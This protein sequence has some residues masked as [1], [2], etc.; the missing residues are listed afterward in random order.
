MK[1]LVASAKKAGFSEAGACRM[2]GVSRGSFR[3][4]P[5]EKRAA[6]TRAAVVAVRRIYAKSKGRYGSPRVYIGLR[7]EGIKHSRK[8]VA[9]L[10]KQEGLVG[11]Q[12]RRFVPTTTDSNH[13]LA[14]APNTLNRQ[15]TVEAPNQV[16]V[17]DITYL[18]I[19]PWAYLATVID[20]YSRRVV[21]WALSTNMHASLATEALNMAFQAR[22]DAKGVLVHHDRGSQYASHAY[23]DCLAPQGANLSMSRKG[24]CWDNAVAEAFFATLKRELGDSFGSFSELYREFAEYI[25]WYN[26]ERYHSHNNYLSPVRAELAYHRQLTA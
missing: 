1:E 5:S 17:G 23:A 26:N 25:E 7:K 3:K 11:A 24:N 21:G 6:K 16:W 19:G 15:F 9:K 22:P 20:L 4:E 18:S 13:R 14:I 2:V 10:M 12:A 8:T